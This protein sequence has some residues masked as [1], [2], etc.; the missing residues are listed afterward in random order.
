MKLTAQNVENVLLACLFNEGEDTIN[1]IIVHG[2]MM[3]V[4][5]HPE[6]LEENRLAITELLFQC[7]ENFMESSEAKGYSFL[8][9]CEDKNGEQWTGE[10]SM[11]DNLICLGL[12]I[13]RVVFLLPREVWA[14]LPGG[15]PYI[16]IKNIL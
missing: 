9:F 10:H 15:M 16:Q 14:V 5:F 13:E 3:K 6:R 8:S 12:A 7:H 1:A 2:V 11:C 4:G